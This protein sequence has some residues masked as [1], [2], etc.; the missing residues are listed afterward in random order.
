[1]N[2]LPADS[3]LGAKQTEKT[4]RSRQLQI[5]TILPP[6]GLARF[7]LV[8][9]Q[10]LPRNVFLPL[11]TLQKMIEQP[12]KVNAILIAGRRDTASSDVEQKLLHAAVKPKLQDFG[13]QVEQINLPT[14]VDLIST[15]EL[16]LPDAVV[17]A[18][19]KTFADR[20][21]QP[22]VTYLAN[23]IVVAG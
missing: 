3:P 21:L 7:G 13:I 8:P 10:Q 16:V 2:A 4:T 14:V 19:E 18:A 11:A 1:V 15:D 20:T 12:G 17:K 5:A 9:S 6:V 23:T 22:V